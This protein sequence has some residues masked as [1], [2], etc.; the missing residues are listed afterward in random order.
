MQLEVSVLSRSGARA[1]NEDACGFWSP[2]GACYCVVSDGAGGHRGGDVASKLVVSQ[3]LS[4][5][6]DRPGCDP[7]AIRDALIAA[8]D[9]VVTERQRDARIADMRATAVVLVIDTEREL[10]AW[11]H[12]GDSRLY[13]YRN[14]RLLVRTRDHSLVQQMIDTGYASD[15][16]F[17]GRPERSRLFAALGDEEGIEPALAQ[18]PLPIEHG[19]AFLLC[20][21]GCWDSVEEHEITAALESADSAEVWLRCLERRINELALAS[22]DNYSALAVLCTRP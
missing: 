17:R 2:P 4:W 5:F 3:I 22:Q 20:T 11:G 1:V 19:D 9:V 8:N 18:H 15:A 14:R 12:L 6:R 7:L 16:D 10:A 21:D 13:C